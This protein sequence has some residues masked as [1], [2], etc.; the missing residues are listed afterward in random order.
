MASNAISYVDSVYGKDRGRHYASPFLC[1]YSTNLS[2]G[3]N[4][5]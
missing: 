1:Y 4:T 3:W 2:F 5:R